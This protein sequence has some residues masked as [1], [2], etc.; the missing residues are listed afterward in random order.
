MPRYSRRQPAADTANHIFDAIS[1]S[2]LWPKPWKSVRRR[3]PG[4]FTIPALIPFIAWIKR[5]APEYLREHYFNRFQFRD[6]VRM[7]AGA[8]GSELRYGGGLVATL[9]RDFLR[10][11]NEDWRRFL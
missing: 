5:E 2:G 9:T 11:Y 1:A 3:H 8:W 4:I 10:G 6:V 7:S